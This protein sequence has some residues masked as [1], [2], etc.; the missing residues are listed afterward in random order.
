MMDTKHNAHTK[1]SCQFQFD[2]TPLEL[3]SM[4]LHL[5]KVLM[6]IG[7][8][9]LWDL[10]IS[11]YDRYVQGTKMSARSSQVGFFLQENQGIFTCKFK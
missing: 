10:I 5:N 6:E 2:S 9:D 11:V 1:C 4:E 7:W 8:R 3:W